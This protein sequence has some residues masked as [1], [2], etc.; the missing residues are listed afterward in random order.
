M[1]KFMTVI[2][3]LAVAGCSNLVVNKNYMNEA[4]SIR[5]MRMPAGQ[6]AVGVV[7]KYPVPRTTAA[8]KTM[9]NIFPPGL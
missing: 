8:G 9:P 4:N 5:P 1:R 6:R 2:A 7:A 3:A